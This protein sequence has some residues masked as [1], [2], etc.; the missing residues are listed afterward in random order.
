MAKDPIS[1]QLASANAA[2]LIN[3]VAIVG[4]KYSA[5]HLIEQATGYNEG[6]SVTFERSWGA[7]CTLSLGF[8]RKGGKCSEKGPH[9]GCE[10]MLPK[11]RVVWPSTGMG[12][13][14]AH[15][16]LALFREVVDLASLLQVTLDRETITDKQEKRSSPPAS[17]SGGTD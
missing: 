5:A 9:K 6:F 11:V 12:P 2:N 10:I 16:C 3:Q 8:E 7:E 14:S 13:L 17:L 1:F 15:V 4:Q